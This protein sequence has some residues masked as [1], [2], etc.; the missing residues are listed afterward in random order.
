MVE[1][2]LS[3]E[4]KYKVNSMDRYNALNTASQILSKARREIYKAEGFSPAWDKLYR[5]GRY[6]DIQSELALKEIVG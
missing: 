1:L 4:G 3:L 2:E 5:V 6:L